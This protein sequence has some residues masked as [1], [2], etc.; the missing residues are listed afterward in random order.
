MPSAL[1]SSRLPWYALLL[2]G[3]GGA[4]VGGVWWYL[5]QRGYNEESESPETTY[6]D[7]NESATQDFIM[8]TA[9]QPLA[10]PL[11]LPLRKTT[12]NGYYNA[13]RP[14]GLKPGDPKIDH[15]H[16]GVDLKGKAGEP[17]LAVGNGRIAT[18]N[19]GKGELVR[20]LL[21]DDGRAVVYADLGTA[22]VEPGAVIKTGQ[23][24]GT[25]RKNGFVHVA[26]RASRYGKF[27]DP[28]GIIPFDSGTK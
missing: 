10:P 26:I 18:A 23:Q 12:P 17:I 28:K 27:M 5:R 1:R 11:M 7:P 25:M 21:L 16:Q 8:P 6:V 20:V 4:A 22:T 14:A 24:I 13:P 2:L 15:Y 3:G 9:K 19:P